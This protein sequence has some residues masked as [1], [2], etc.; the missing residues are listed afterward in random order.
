M[1]EPLNRVSEEISVNTSGTCSVLTS[2]K[3]VGII[4]KLVIDKDREHLPFGPYLSW[5]LLTWSALRPLSG[6]VPKYPKTSSTDFVNASSMVE[7]LRCRQFYGIE[8]EEVR[9]DESSHTT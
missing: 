8:T 1:K 6:S 2:S 7:L 9:N 5:F 3:P 4:C